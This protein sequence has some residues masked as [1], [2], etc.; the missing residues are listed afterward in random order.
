MKGELV[1]TIVIPDDC[2]AVKVGNTIEIRKRVA[3]QAAKYHC[4]NCKYLI[5]GYATYRGQETTVCALKPK[6]FPQIVQSR[7]LDMSKELHY[8]TSLWSKAC[9]DFKK[10]DNEDK[11]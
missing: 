6:P 10:K 1:K 2:V 7:Q 8:N 5:L 11:H 4:R 9:K 3:P